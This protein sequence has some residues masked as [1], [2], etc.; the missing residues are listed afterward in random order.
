MLN[1]NPALSCRFWLG[2]V[3]QPHVPILI[4]HVSWHLVFLAVQLEIPGDP[5]KS[6]LDDSSAGKVVPGR[7]G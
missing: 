5:N 7:D 3:A 6:E 4:F 2:K 1:L